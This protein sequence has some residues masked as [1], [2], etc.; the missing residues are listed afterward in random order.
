MRRFNR[1]PRN[2]FRVN[3]QKNNTETKRSR[4]LDMRKTEEFNFMLNKIVEELPDSVR[5]AI[6]GGLYS[7]ASKQGTKEAREYIS[8]I[9]EDGIIDDNTQK[10]LY[11]LI[12]DYSKVR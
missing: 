9:Y 5:G 11:N 10:R 6:K 1:K 12:G 8:K 4:R 2:F 7:I 3:T